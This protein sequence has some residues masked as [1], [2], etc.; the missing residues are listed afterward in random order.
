MEHSIGRAVFRQLTDDPWAAFRWIRDRAPI[1]GSEGEQLS[2]LSDEAAL[3]ELVHG[4]AYAM[5]M[6]NPDRA[7]GCFSD[8]ASLVH[9]DVL[10]RRSDGVA[11]IAAHLR[12]LVAQFTF[13]RHRPAN[14]IVRVLPGGTE[15]WVSVYLHVATENDGAVESRFERCFGRF[16]RNGE[17]WQFADWCIFEDFVLGYSEDAG[18]VEQ[19]LPLVDPDHSLP[20]S[21]A[22]IPSL[23][24]PADGGRSTW[25]ALRDDLWNAHH[26][27]L[28]SDT[29]EIDSGAKLNQLVDEVAI[30]EV[31]SNYAYAH[32]SHDL[33]WCGSV[34]TEDAIIYNELQTLN[35][36]GEIVDLFRGWQ[37]A[38]FLSFHR[39]SN[40]IIRFVPECDDAWLLAYF[41]V[42]VVRFDRSDY[43]FGRYFSRLTKRSGRWQIAD[44][45]IAADFRAQ[46][47]LRSTGPHDLIEWK[48]APNARIPMV[49]KK[50][51][52]FEVGQ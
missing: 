2:Q 5:D 33:A 14:F 21:R 34:F 41:H 24:P 20:A 7:S 11:E 45:R 37:G 39:F 12:D 17:R 49:L 50:S 4:F 9:R 40:P 31:L 16:E 43:S 15:A 18:V 52:S 13:S 28:D 23:N 26:W 48:T 38:G 1:S 10:D 32:D 8:E 47:T 29:P 46:P 44:W 35:G 3:R 27:L 22:W 25:L 19:D 42:E 51:S 30:R 6:K 36:N